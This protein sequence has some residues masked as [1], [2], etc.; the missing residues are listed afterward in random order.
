MRRHC[1]SDISLYDSTF[2]FMTHRGQNGQRQDITRTRST[3]NE[4]RQ[5]VASELHRALRC[6]FNKSTNSYIARHTLHWNIFKSAPSILSLQRYLV[7]SSFQKSKYSKITF[8]HYSCALSRE[9]V[10]GTTF[11]QILSR[12]TLD[13]YRTERDFL[14]ETIALESVILWDILIAWQV[15]A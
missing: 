5:S 8:F 6:I 15:G 7:R 12:I 4:L 9:A 3:T 11:H 14:S 2:I 13:S 10:K 1:W